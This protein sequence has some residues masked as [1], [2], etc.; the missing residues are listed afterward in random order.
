M[1][2][3]AS[4][5]SVH[6]QLTTAHSQPNFKDLTTQNERSPIQQRG[7]F[8]SKTMVVTLKMQIKAVTHMTRTRVMTMSIMFR[9]TITENMPGLRQ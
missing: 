5:V 8:L 6:S 4:T 9:L 3:W 7:Q 1:K 2:K